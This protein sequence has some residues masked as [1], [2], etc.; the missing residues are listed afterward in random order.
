M[1]M[2][3]PEFEI[4]KVVWHDA[5]A[6]PEEGW[7]YVEDIDD[8]D[9]M[10]VVHIGFL[11]PVNKGGKR[12]HVTLCFGITDA[13]AL[14]TRIHIPRKMVVSVER[15]VENGTVRLERNPRVPKKSGAKGT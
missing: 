2:S 6:A 8:P 5:H 15:L 9:P 3:T 1:S 7:V 4:V 10:P 14:D 11:L 13:G 12:G